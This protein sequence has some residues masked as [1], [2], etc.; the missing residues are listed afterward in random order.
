MSGDLLSVSKDDYKDIIDRISVPDSPVG[1]DA[2][3]THAVIIAYLRE[4]VARLDR[5]EA[6][7]A[8][9]Q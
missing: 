9:G 7:T 6:R 5:L 2:Q 1:I 3:L 4:I 8:G